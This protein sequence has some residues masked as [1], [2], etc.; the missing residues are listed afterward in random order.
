MVEK[1]SWAILGTGKP[2]ENTRM[3]IDPMLKATAKGEPIRKRTIINPNPMYWAN[4][5]RFFSSA[6][7]YSDGLYRLPS[8]ADSFND[9]NHCINGEN[10]HPDRYTK[11]RKPFGDCNIAGPEGF[12]GIELI[13]KMDTAK[14]NKRTIK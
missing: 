2:T 12:A 6:G 5:M 7:D 11:L 10:E 1:N 9:F 4:S 13:N 8:F 3:T 14:G